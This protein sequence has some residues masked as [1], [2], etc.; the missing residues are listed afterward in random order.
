M[1]GIDAA[2]TAHNPSGVAMAVGTAE[3]WRVEAAASSYA[4]FGVKHGPGME[5]ELVRV[6]EKTARCRLSLVTVDM[7][8]SRHPIT[9][10][11]VSDRK[12][13]S[14]YGSRKCATHSPG[15]LRPG[16]I[17]DSLRAEFEAL[18]F[19]LLTQS[20]SSPG[21]AEVY[22]H[23][24]LVELTGANERL[25]YKVSRAGSYWKQEKPSP[26]ERRNRIITEWRRI[27]L[28]L[29]TQL[30]GVGAHLPH[31]TAGST[32]R[33]LKAFEDTLDAIICCWIGICIL[34]GRANAYGD[35]TSAIWVPC[36]E[37]IRR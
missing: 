1:L 36:G 32:G 8:L 7:P 17:S 23:P 6:V 29:E 25:K 21:L 37:L 33:E 28:A 31:V 3:G 2:W 16:K 18:G 35:A 24:A 27:T 15:A 30:S 10:R 14:A 13:S 11:R 4:Q 19:P 20:V 26:E 22:P 9:G 34:E 12:V 5:G